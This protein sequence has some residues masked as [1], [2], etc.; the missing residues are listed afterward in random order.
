MRRHEISLIRSS[1]ITNIIWVVIV[2]E[3]ILF[4]YPLLEAATA[5]G[6][7]VIFV[8]VHTLWL[9]AIVPA[10]TYLLYFLSV[11]FQNYKSPMERII[12]FIVAASAII[13]IITCSDL[14]YSHLVE[15]QNTSSNG[16][17]L[18]LR[19][20]IGQETSEPAGFVEML[21]DAGVLKKIDP[22]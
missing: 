15:Y 5:R 20:R 3:S 17:R 22:R 14:Y 4:A 7:P 8:P 18:Q 2:L 16:T 13:I 9:V 11:S 19:N 21:N 1:I 12:T 6:E 10:I